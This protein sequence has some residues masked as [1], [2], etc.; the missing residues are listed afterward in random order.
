MK[1]PIKSGFE[2]DAIYARRIYKFTQR[3]GVCRK[4]KR[5]INRRARHEWR[6]KMQQESED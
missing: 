5:Q 2:E 3:P 6:L 4:A 1:Q